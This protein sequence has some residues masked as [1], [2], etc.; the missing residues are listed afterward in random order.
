MV[1]IFPLGINDTG[2]I[3]LGFKLAIIAVVTFAVHLTLSS[4]FGLEEAEPIVR[5]LKSIRDVLLRPVRIDI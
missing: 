3:T 4:L 5:K 2:F 1:T